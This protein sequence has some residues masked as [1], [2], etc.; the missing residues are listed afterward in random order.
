MECEHSC[1]PTVL[2]IF[3]I[4]ERRATMIRVEVMKFSNIHCFG[5]QNLWQPASLERPICARVGSSRIM[6]FRVFLAPSE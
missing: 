4:S 1:A 6:R 3:W 5:P 2:Q